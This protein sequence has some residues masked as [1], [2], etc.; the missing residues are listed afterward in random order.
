MRAGCKAQRETSG[1]GRKSVRTVPWSRV[2][3]IADAAALPVRKKSARIRVRRSAAEPESIGRELNT[4]SEGCRV[5]CEQVVQVVCKGVKRDAGTAREHMRCEVSNGA[6]GFSRRSQST[7]QTGSHRRVC[8]RMPAEVRGCFEGA[9]RVSALEYKT[10]SVAFR[11]VT[12][13]EGLVRHSR[14]AT[15]EMRTV[16]GAD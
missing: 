13:A 4:S 3:P 2:S 6:L 15:D 12:V 5:E 11:T 7:V 16:G 14:G 9:L 10:V 1:T 8:V